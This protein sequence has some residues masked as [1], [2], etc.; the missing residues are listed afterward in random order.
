MHSG[1]RSILDFVLVLGIAFLAG[2]VAQKFRLSSVL[3]YL[4]TGLFLG[5]RAF[6]LVREGEGLATFGEL[7]VALF[8]FSIGLEFSWSK[9]RRL[10][11]VALGG[12][13]S[14]LVLTA[15]AGWVLG[16]AFGLGPTESLVAG[17]ALTLSSTAVVLGVLQERR[18]LEAPFGRLAFGVLILQDAMLLPIMLVVTFLVAPSPAGGMAQG[19]LAPLL[20]TAKIVIAGSV[21]Y[22]LVGRVLPRFYDSKTLAKNRDLAVLLAV[23]ACVGS[24]W[25]AHEVGLSPSLGA[26]LAGMLLAG[27]PFAVQIRADIGPLRAIFVTLFFTTVGMMVDGKWLVGNLPLVLSVAGLILLVKVVV[28][29]ASFRGFRESILTSLAA[30]IAIGQV[31]EFSFVLFQT[32][33][34]SGFFEETAHQLMVSASMVTVLATPLLAPQSQRISRWI[35]S[36]AVPTRK[37]AVDERAHQP[38]GPSGHVV[39]V[40][41]GESGQAAARPLLDARM[42]L[43]VLDVDPRMVALA[44]RRGLQA[45]VGDATVWEVLRAARIEQ[46]R[47]LAVSIPNHDS[48][49]MIIETA[50]RINPTLVIAARARYRADVQELAAAGA[51]YVVDESNLTGQRLGQSLVSVSIPE[52]VSLR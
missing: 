38:I 23:V 35:A 52:G 51:D 8:L 22:L 34:A 31:G 46:A 5:P 42:E 32:A 12:G 44:R 4:I 41:F 40:G 19:W 17:L 29:Y 33:R 36:R 20:V 48:S 24:A 49:R 14:Q 9:L 30:A 50:K 47:A 1:W 45:R 13:L 15:V 16:W 27:T 25:A 6:G 39:L 10:G 7:G 18:Q 21:L 11:P 37:L 28:A 43:F 3:G 26:F 2:A